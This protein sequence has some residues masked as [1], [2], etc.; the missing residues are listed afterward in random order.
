MGSIL[1][2]A[3]P[4]LYPFI[5]EYSLI[6]AA[7][8][9]VMWSTIGRGKRN[10]LCNGNEN[11]SPPTSPI[12]PGLQIDNMSTSSS[13]TYNSN[14]PTLYSCLGSSKGTTSRIFSLYSIGLL[15]SHIFIGLFTGFLFLAISVTSLI[16]FFVLVHNPN[17]N[18]MA[19]L[20]SD[21]SHSILLIP[22]LYRYFIGISQNQKIEVSTGYTYIFIIL[23][24]ICASNVKF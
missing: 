11:M 21:I 19:T 2:D 22:L 7:F 8:L 13:N 15:K 12:S 6:G 9:Y 16:I 17:Y 4:Y 1:S 3:S 18:L 14:S 24:I 10:N 20:I 5:V 23:N